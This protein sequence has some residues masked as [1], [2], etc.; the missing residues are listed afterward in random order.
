LRRGRVDKRSAIG[1]AHGLISQDKGAAPR[2]RRR[3]LA[4]VADDAPGRQLRERRRAVIGG[5]AAV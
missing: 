3:I 2:G 5:A 1:S 4:V